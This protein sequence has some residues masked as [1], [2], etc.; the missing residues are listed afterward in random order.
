MV[1]SNAGIDSNHILF[2]PKSNQ[3]EIIQNEFKRCEAIYDV[4]RR[5][6]IKTGTF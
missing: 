1:I 5:E 3:C 6:Y 4:R 2:D